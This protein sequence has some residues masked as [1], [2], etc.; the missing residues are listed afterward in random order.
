MFIGFRSLLLCV[1]LTI[2]NSFTVDDIFVKAVRSRTADGATLKQGRQP[3]DS[4]RPCVMY[5]RILQQLASFGRHESLKSNAQVTL[6]QEIGVPLG[7]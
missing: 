7:R 3:R 1:E 6:E 2:L 5:G 4:W